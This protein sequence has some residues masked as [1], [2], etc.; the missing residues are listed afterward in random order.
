M[1]RKNQSQNDENQDYRTRNHRPQ[2]ARHSLCVG[3]R[4][5]GG[6]VQPLRLQCVF[7]HHTFF[8]ETEIACHRAN[9]SAIERA[10]GKAVP[11]LV[12][13][14]FQKSRA[15]AR[16]SSDFL[17]GHAAHFALAPQVVAER[18]RR[19]PEVLRLIIFEAGLKK[20]KADA[21]GLGLFR[22]FERRSEGKIGFSSPFEPSGNAP[23]KDSQIVWI[24]LMP[25][26][27][28]R[29]RRPALEVRLQV[30]NAADFSYSQTLVLLSQS[31]GES[32]LQRGKTAPYNARGLA[33]LG[34]RRDL[35]KIPPTEAMRKVTE[36][37][38]FEGVE[39]RRQAGTSFPFAANDG[40][41]VTVFHELGKALT[42][43]LQL[44]Q[45]LRT[46][47]EKINEVLRPD[48]WSLLLMDQDKQELYFEIAT[49]KGADRLKDLRIK[50]GQGLAGWVAESGTAVVVPDTS[51]DS[52]FFAQVDSRTK[53]ETRS[54]VAVPVRFRDQCL[55]VI[56]LI[57]C[58]GPEGFSARDL[59]LLEALADYAAI[60]IENARHVQRIH[61]LTITDDCTSLYNARHMNFMLDTEIYRSHRYAFEFSLI[62]IDLDH[63]KQINDTHGHLMGSKLLAEIGAAIKEKCRL[64]DL[65]FRYGGDEFV[66]LLPQT[67]KE[68][69][70]GVARRVHKLIR[71]TKWL[72]DPGLNV[73]ITASVGV[74]SYPTDS[75]T[76][77]ELL[78]LADDA[79]Y[80][81]KNTTRDC[82]AVAG[83]GLLQ[84]EQ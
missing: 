28:I 60:A 65:A 4:R 16:G 19:H 18:C 61:E 47:M 79:M 48:T 72:S 49:G 21:Q 37:K 40:T 33:S 44:D 53:M 77:A 9:K 67:S 55:G 35:V 80:L 31:V 51:Q 39:R 24:A 52:R 13:N 63:F 3:L 30:G 57:N 8:I 70:M 84:K 15:D 38:P 6:L 75:R 41:E 29:H 1:D 20:S 34:V 78:H 25:R 5:S 76:K 73:N 22:R 14:R 17:N 43:S 66:I 42:S 68:N 46:I 62:F 71:E 36:E 69:A 64:I 50:V 12:F 58:V 81:V 56:E 74:A 23:G 27:A 82:V 45:V 26:N 2:V 32:S 7:G 54:I 11:L 10:A 59:A 83:M